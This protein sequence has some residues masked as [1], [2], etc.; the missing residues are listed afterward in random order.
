MMFFPTVDAPRGLLS[1]R[2]LIFARRAG[3]H[4]LVG[5]AAVVGV[6]VRKYWR[7]DRGPS[8]QIGSGARILRS[9]FMSGIRPIEKRSQHDAAAVRPLF[10]TICMALCNATSAGS[11][12]RG[13]SRSP[14]GERGI[15]GDRD[16]TRGQIPSCSDANTRFLSGRYG[17]SHRSEQATA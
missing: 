2:S 16:L 1:S 3:D 15:I 6:A 10:G 9:C 14:S 7:E 13:R 8:P 12:W 17:L 4:L 5:G 11:G